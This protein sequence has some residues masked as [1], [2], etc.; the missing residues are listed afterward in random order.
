MNP[1]RAFGPAVVY[2]R[3]ND[4]KYNSF[5]GHWIYWLGPALGAGVAGLIYRL[6]LANNG[7]RIVL[8]TE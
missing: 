7:R 5:T 3:Y 4:A 8:K 2:S 1:A 6:V